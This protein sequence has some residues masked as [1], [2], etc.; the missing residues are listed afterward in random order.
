MHK[1]SSVS[2]YIFKITIM[3]DQSASTFFTF[4]KNQV[5]N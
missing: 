4:P 2:N 1:P 3:E 5:M